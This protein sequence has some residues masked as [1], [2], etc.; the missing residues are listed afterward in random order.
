MAKDPATRH[1]SASELVQD[2]TRCFA[3]PPAEP[4][5][6]SETA[7][8]AAEPAPAAATAATPDLTTPGP[9]A[10]VAAPRVPTALRA[11]P[12]AR[13]APAARAPRRRAPV[14]LVAG[15]GLVVLVVA[16]FLVGSAMSGDDSAPQR[17]APIVA[18]DLSARGPA[19]WK[20]ADEP[21]KVKGLTLRE[22]ASV[23]PDRTGEGTSITIGKS[24]GTGSTLLPPALVR[25]LD[26]PAPSP[27]RV[28]LGG[29]L[30]A[31]RY[32]GL[33]PQ[34]LESGTL[35]LYVAPIVGGV[36]TVQCVEPAD[37]VPGS[38][39]AACDQTAA[40]LELR[41]GKALPLGPDE[42]YQRTLDRV[43]KRLNGA[44]KGQAAT[45]RGADT[46]GAQA[47]AADSLRASYRSAARSLRGATANPQVTGANK[48]IIAALEGL[49]GRYEQL[50]TAAR[51]DDAAAYGKARFFIEHGAEER[52][53]P[54]A[55]RGRRLTTPRARRRGGTPAGRGS[56]RASATWRSCPPS[57][58]SAR[59]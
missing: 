48:R 58:R 41:K 59:A 42:G 27:K 40:S 18:G 3:R 22:A 52:L 35:R 12:P 2:L 14:P 50:A 51:A 34:G 45:L 39:T 17:G 23:A 7:L 26:E 11:P 9:T 24:R 46:P 25:Q 19:A 4:F 53:R 16:G 57:R 36:A 5:T 21:V 10:P 43:V 31:L 32:S 8:R 33:G 55:P 15:A 6:D 56:P 38:T 13:P 47:R 28:E 44:T 37:V 29:D 30:Q 20:R 49:A 1:S 54:R